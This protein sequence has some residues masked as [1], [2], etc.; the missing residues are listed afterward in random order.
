MSGNTH[1]GEM[2]VKQKQTRIKGDQPVIETTNEDGERKT[3]FPQESV[4]VLGGNLQLN[5]GWSA[6]LETGENPLLPAI[7]K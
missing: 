6:H 1:I 3:V 7:R 2:M 4:R 5:L